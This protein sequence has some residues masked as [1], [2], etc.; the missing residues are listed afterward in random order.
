VVIW[1]PLCAL[2]RGAS[3]VKVCFWGYGLVQEASDV[4]LT[5]LQ[6]FRLL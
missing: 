1:Y 2:S 3:R 6:A 5:Y 4:S